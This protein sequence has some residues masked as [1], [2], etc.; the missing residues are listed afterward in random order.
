M[1]F[2]EITLPSRDTTRVFFDQDTEE[3]K[4]TVC[5]MGDHE[6]RSLEQLKDSA[7]QH[8]LLGCRFAEVDGTDEDSVSSWR[9]V[10]QDDVHTIPFACLPPSDVSQRL[11]VALLPPLLTSDELSKKRTFAIEPKYCFV[12]FTAAEQKIILWDMAM[13]DASP[14]PAIASPGRAVPRLQLRGIAPRQP[15]CQVRH[16][17]ERMQL[18]ATC[19]SSLLCPPESL[20][21]TPSALPAKPLHTLSE[22]SLAVASKSLP[23]NALYTLG[24]SILLIHVPA[25]KLIAFF[26]NGEPET[27][28]IKL[29]MGIM[30]KTQSEKEKFLDAQALIPELKT[31]IA[32]AWNSDPVQRQTKVMS[33]LAAAQDAPLIDAAL[34]KKKIQNTVQFEKTCLPESTLRTASTQSKARQADDPDVLPG[35]HRRTHSI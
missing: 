20:N 23:A 13:P 3:V 16:L 35:R 4:V 6:P 24:M 31:F 25:E 9:F 10:R 28:I 21:P 7:R 8:P 12:H 19:E 18:D 26:L 27:T 33:W 15:R 32:A 34:Q 11:L 29:L 22:L 5:L 30:S 1:P 2:V 17:V 14:V